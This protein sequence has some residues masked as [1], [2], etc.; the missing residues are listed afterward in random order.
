MN[1]II[2]ANVDFHNRTETQINKPTG[3]RQAK[4]KMY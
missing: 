2:I 4:L 1:V 3:I